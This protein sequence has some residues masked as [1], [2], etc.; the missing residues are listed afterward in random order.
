MAEP[1]TDRPAPIGPM[2]R[3]LWQESVNEK[4]LAELS[5][6]MQRF[7]RQGFAIKTEWLEEYNE[8]ISHK[9]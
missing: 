7:I 1:D 5:E 8:L 3:K 4:R 6:V 2:P 9:P